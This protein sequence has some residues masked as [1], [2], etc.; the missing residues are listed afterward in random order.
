LRAALANGQAHV[1]N[2][3]G[4]VPES[5]GDWGW[6]PKSR[7]LGWDPQGTRIGWV[8]GNDL[9]LEPT[10]SYQIAQDLAGNE[11]LTLS[12]QTLHHR[13]RESGLLASIDHGRQM[14]QVRRTLEGFPRQVLHLKATDLVGQIQEA[15][16]CQPKLK[17]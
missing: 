10:A 2:R 7:S 14:V 1:A 5:P 6:R 13:L 16:R 8:T 17:M 11:R 4:R 12:Q 15:E 9:F 3:R